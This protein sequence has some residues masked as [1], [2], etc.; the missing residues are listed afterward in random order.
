MARSDEGIDS[1]DEDNDGIGVS[2]IQGL[3]TVAALTGRIV[4]QPSRTNLNAMKIK[5]LRSKK[6]NNAQ[7]L[8]EKL[9]SQKLI[10]GALNHQLISSVKWT[11]L[12]SCM[13]TGQL[14]KLVENIHQET[15]HESDTFK[16]LDP[17][18]FA[19]KANS[20]DT[21][22]YEEAMNGPLPHDFI[23]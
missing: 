19:A 12:K 14:G 9:S 7:E 4:R 21:P 6:T 20:E 11:Q 13:L 1:D 10:A 22:T 23:K 2:V 8:R 16:H 17:S 3:P 18:I 5:E 15:D